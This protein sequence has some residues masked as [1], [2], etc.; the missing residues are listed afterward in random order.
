MRRLFSYENPDDHD[1][2]DTQGAILRMLK[3]M[4]MIQIEGEFAKEMEVGA[5]C[6]H[7]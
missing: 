5:S 3:E 2:L 1:A 4:G 7:P 6:H